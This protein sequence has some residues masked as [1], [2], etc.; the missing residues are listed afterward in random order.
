MA[1]AAQAPP[2]RRLQHLRLAKRRGAQKQKRPKPPSSPAP[3]TVRCD[4]SLPAC[5]EAREDVKQQ[6]HDLQARRSTISEDLKARTAVK[7]ALPRYARIN[8]L[9][10]GVTWGKVQRELQ[11]S[12]HTF[13][14]PSLRE[15]REAARRPS[16]LEPPKGSGNRIYYRDIHIPEMLVFKPM[17]QSH[18]EDVEMFDQGCLIFQQKASAFP[19]LALQPPC[20]G[21]VI[22]ACAAPGS[23]TSQ[24][25]AMMCNQ[26]TIYAFDRDGKRLK[27][28]TNLMEQRHVTCVEAR[29][30]DF[31][32]VST[33]DPKYS[34]V[35]HFLLDPSCSS[36]GMTAQPIS[37]PASLQEL[38]TNQ[39]AVI[40]H[41]MRFPSCERI[42]YSTCSVHEEENE[43]VVQQVLASEEGKRYHLEEALPWWPRRGLKL[44]HFPEAERC[45]RS[46]WE[47]RTIGFF[48]ALF[49][50]R[51][52]DA[53]ML[54][55]SA[56]DGVL[57]DTFK[58]GGESQ[59]I[60]RILELFAEAYFKQWGQNKEKS[61]P[62]TAYA[63]ADSVLA[64][65]FSLIMLNTSLHVASKKAKSPSASMTSTEFVENTR[66]VVSEQEV[67]EA[68]LRQFY[69]DV[70]K[71]EIS[72]QPMPRVAFSRLPVQPDIEGWLIVL[73][74]AEDQRRFWA[75]LALQRLYLFSD[76]SDVDPADACDLKDASAGKILD[77]ADARE[78]YQALQS[79]GKGKCFCFPRGRGLVDP[80]T[81]RR[82]FAVNQKSDG[83]W[84]SKLGHPSSH[85]IL[86][87][88]PIVL[89]AMCF[90]WCSSF[91]SGEWFPP[92][93]LRP[94]PLL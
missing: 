61:L 69:A 60:N 56:T 65:A 64:T 82:A 28:L 1:L 35:T 49:A 6:L 34:K 20:G 30:K 25:A 74:G 15:K 76:N 43:Q 44:P 14:R 86:V 4:V 50:R 78:R 47:D 45:V 24:L 57:F 62:E 53:Q 17:G 21:Q 67:P 83:T 9:A 73:L 87:R 18:T 80:D 46:A 79:R 90:L 12:G 26:G 58:P 13:W 40:L 10:P 91:S 71:A 51:E 54:F 77:D 32:Q 7:R 85:L 52:K 3:A 48:V 5:H 36:S 59:V 68:A 39:K 66:R 22:D 42:A 84:L 29:E 88:P 75:V 70:K 81:E 33:R 27:T 23:K 94:N 31:L 2:R 11:S 89:R 19:A 8:M 37:D 93:P 55:P 38:A 72:M 63:A 16:G 92:L 41:A